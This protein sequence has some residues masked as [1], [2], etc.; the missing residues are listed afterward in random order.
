MGAFYD[1][2]IYLA[3]ALNRTIADDQNPYDGITVAQKLWNNTFAG[4]TYHYSMHLIDKTNSNLDP[5]IIDY[6]AIFEKTLCLRV[7]PESN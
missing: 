2:V 5:L 4:E 6:I 7:S 3:M 1:S